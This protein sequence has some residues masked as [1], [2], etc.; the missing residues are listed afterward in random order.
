MTPAQARKIVDE[1]RK[2]NTSLLALGNVITALAAGKTKHIPYRDSKLTRLLQ[3]SLGGNSR[4]AIVVCCS[5]SEARE[6]GLVARRASQPADCRGPSAG[7]RARVPL[8]APLRRPFPAH[9]Q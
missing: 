7:Q 8:D 3:N 6:H 4:T 5:P 2:I 9:P 1:G